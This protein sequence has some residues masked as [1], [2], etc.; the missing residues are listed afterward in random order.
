MRP[1]CW[2]CFVASDVVYGTYVDDGR[3]GFI[4]RDSEGWRAALE[5]LVTDSGLRRHVGAAAREH[6]QRWDVT[7]TGAEQM[8]AMLATFGVEVSG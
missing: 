3:T 5:R 6:V 4:A 7:T 2:A 8:R 1:G